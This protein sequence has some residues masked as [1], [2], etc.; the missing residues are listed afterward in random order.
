MPQRTRRV[1]LPPN[2][3]DRALADSGNTTEIFCGT[4]GRASLSV[5]PKPFLSPGLAPV[6]FHLVE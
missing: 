4:E 6:R 1:Q 5:P 3:E 2:S